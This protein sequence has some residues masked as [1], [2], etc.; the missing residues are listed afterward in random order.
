M[1]E[2]KGLGGEVP[3]Q[4]IARAIEVRD[5][6]YRLGAHWHG[7]EL[8][9]WLRMIGAVDD[10]SD[11]SPEP[12]RRLAEGDWPTASRWWD[13]RGIPYETAVALSFGD[14]EARLEALGLLDQ[15]SAIPLASRIRAELGNAGVRGVP[16]GPQKATRE[17]PMGLTS[18][19]TDV[20]QLLTEDLTNAEIA[21]RVSIS[22]RTVDHHVS[23]ILIKIGAT[24]RSEAAE[25]AREALTGL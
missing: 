22:T 6:C 2:Y 15:L 7:A 5:L 14:V 1:V 12:Y 11:L 3:E 24:S 20:L 21:D 18:R 19:Q 13:D 17:N 25:K 16:R 10:I 4:Q 23:A 9:Q 8:G